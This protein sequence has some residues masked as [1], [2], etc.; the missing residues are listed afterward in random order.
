MDTL[1]LYQAKKRR[2]EDIDL[3]NIPFVPKCA[4]FP[5]DLLTDVARVFADRA[6][7]PKEITVSIK[8]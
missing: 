2:P 7:A 8:T 1:A 4:V 6:L 3:E 5:L